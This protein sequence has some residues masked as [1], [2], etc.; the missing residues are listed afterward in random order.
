[1]PFVPAVEIEFI[2][3]PR[4][5]ED[6]GGEFLT[7]TTDDALPLETDLYVYVYDGVTEHRCYSGV[8]GSGDVIRAIDANTVRFVVPELPIGGAY[9]VRVK[10]T[11][12]ALQTTLSA[13][14]QVVARN[15]ETKVFDLRRLYPPWYKTGPRSVDSVDLLE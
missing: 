9:D 6:K 10:T 4:Y 14:L 8:A 7:V 3:T 13:F 15:W 11:G 2:A 1:M 12:G 5:V